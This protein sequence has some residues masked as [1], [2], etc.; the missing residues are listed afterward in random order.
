M[1][2]SSSS[3]QTSAA[4]SLPIVNDAEQFWLADTG[5]ASSVACLQVKLEAAQHEAQVLEIKRQGQLKALE[6]QKARKQVCILP[7]IEAHIGGV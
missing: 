2:H 5:A 7:S 1:L 6:A 3:L 4:V